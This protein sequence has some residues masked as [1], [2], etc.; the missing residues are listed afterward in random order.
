MQDAFHTFQTFP[1]SENRIAYRKANAKF[2][3]EAKLAKRD[4]FHKFTSTIAPNTPIKSLW[5]IVNK[6]YNKFSPSHIKFIE[7]DDIIKTSDSTE[8]NG[9]KILTIATSLLIL[10]LKRD[11]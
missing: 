6:L 8:A 1:T 2:K 11:T 5:S 3:G 4:T 10:I 9:R 7:V